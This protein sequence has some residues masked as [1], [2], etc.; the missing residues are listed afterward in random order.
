MS[1]GQRLVLLLEFGEQPH[2]LDGNHGLV[3]EG[4]QQRDVAV[5]GGP[6]LC[7][8]HYDRSDRGAASQHWDAHGTANTDRTSQLLK[9]QLLILL[10]IGYLDY[11]TRKD[12]LAHEQ[13][14][15]RA[16]WKCT[17]GSFGALRFCSYGSKPNGSVRRR[18][19]R[20]RRRPHCRV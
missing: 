9:L 3:G 8:R 17:S 7:A 20:V 6:R 2:I 1:L 19:D 5:G 15:T 18:S 13:S 16:C 12:R 11:G 10:E 14:S 4:L